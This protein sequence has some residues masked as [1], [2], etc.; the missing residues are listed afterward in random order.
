MWPRGEPFSWPTKKVTEGIKR[1]R[2]TKRR[3]KRILDCVKKQGIDTKNMGN[4]AGKHGGGGGADDDSGED[5]KQMAVPRGTKGGL[6]KRGGSGTK[7]TKRATKRGKGWAYK[8]T[9]RAQLSHIDSVL[10]ALYACP[11]FK[12]LLAKHRSETAYHCDA[13]LKIFEGV[14]K[15]EEVKD[16]IRKIELLSTTLEPDDFLNSLLTELHHETMEKAAP[17]GAQA[18]QGSSAY[19]GGKSAIS[20]FFGGILETQVYCLNCM[21]DRSPR[22]AEMFLVLKIPMPPSGH[23]KEFIG[24]SDCL[25]A[26]FQLE[27][28][29]EP[30]RVS[31]TLSHYTVLLFLSPVKALSAFVT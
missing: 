4:E 6:T 24:I 7:G 27:A 21:G 9:H 30:G 2:A 16:D 15:G 18:A 8:Q 20:E 13:L 17:P 19:P 3:D 22:V 25:D 28:L 1:N 26:R 14:A 12:H 29:K 31:L 5:G 10:H 11:G 23:H